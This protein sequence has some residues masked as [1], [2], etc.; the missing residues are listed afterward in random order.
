MEVDITGD[1]VLQ[2]CTV[3]TLARTEGELERSTL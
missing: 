3:D 2:F 1:R